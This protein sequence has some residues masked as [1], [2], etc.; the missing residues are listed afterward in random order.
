[1]KAFQATLERTRSRLN[2]VFVRIPFDVS[3][4][5]GTR[6]HLRVKGEISGFEFRASLFDRS[7]R[8]PVLSPLPP[9][10][11]LDD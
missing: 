6:G 11:L 8:L 5:W 10:T 4:I 2:W 3:K 9:E 1:M 7:E